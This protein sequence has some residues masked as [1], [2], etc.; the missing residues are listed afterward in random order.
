MSFPSFYKKDKNGLFSVGCAGVALCASII[1]L[2]ACGGKKSLSEEPPMEFGHPFFVG[3]VGQSNFLDSQFADYW[4]QITPENEG[5]WTVVERSRDEY[6]WDGL[7]AIYNFSKEHG[8]IFKGHTLIWGAPTPAWMA[9]ISPEEMRME[10]EEWMGDFCARYPDVTLIDV[11]NEALPGH[12]PLY[13]AQQA[14]G[15]DWVVESFR[16]ARRNC[17]DAILILNDYH[18]LSWSTDEFIQFVTPIIASGEVDA[19]GAQAHG[20]EDFSAV[21]VSA[22]LEQIAAL[23]L[24]IYISEFDIPKQSDEEQLA[25]MQELFPVFYHHPSVAGITFW[26][27]IEGTTFQSSAHLVRS[28]GSPRPA[29]VWVQEYMRNNPRSLLSR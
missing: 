20:L 5:K 14:L 27:N 28:D 9:Q 11:V 1:T 3:N 24:P 7:D 18:L 6:Y 15:Q 26:G 2:V 12:F 21:E 4:D 8:L 13:I 22:K 23:G 16:M 25:V 29:L 17:P 10:M 19:I